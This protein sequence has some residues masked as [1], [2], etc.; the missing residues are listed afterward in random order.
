M[1]FG[2]AHLLKKKRNK[3]KFKFNKILTL[4]LASPLV[5]VEMTA[6]SAI[7]NFDVVVFVN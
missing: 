3:T 7:V 5:V 2:N 6:K 1:F 4:L